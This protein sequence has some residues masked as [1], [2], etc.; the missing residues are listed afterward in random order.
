MNT[1][2]NSAATAIMGSQI[3]THIKFYHKICIFNV[4]FTDCNDLSLTLDHFK[5]TPTS[6]KNK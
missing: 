6:N 1:V 5:K 4:Q 3:L 2:N